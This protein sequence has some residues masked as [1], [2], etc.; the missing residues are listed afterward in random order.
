MANALREKPRFKISNE[1]K[2]D[3]S[4]R[5]DDQLYQIA[6]KGWVK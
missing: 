1:E 4:K 5:K 3:I 2:Y 6:L